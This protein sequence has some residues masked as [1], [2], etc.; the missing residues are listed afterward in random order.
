MKHC[1][2]PGN[3]FKE[4]ATEILKVLPDDLLFEDPLR[5]YLS[6]IRL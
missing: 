6:V 3:V 2:N 1:N 5:M 4:N